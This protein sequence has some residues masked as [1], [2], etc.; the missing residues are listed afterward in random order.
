MHKILL[1]TCH[2]NKHLY[3]EFKDKK[4]VNGDSVKCPSQNTRKLSFI[5]WKVPFMIE[6]YIINHEIYHQ[7]KNKLAQ[8]L[9]YHLP[10]YEL[11]IQ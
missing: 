6:K 7:V 5:A 8:C 9:T 3:E 10:M 11:H 4:K 1:N 2:R